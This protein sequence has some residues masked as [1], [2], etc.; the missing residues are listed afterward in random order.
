MKTIVNRTEKALSFA[1]AYIVPIIVIIVSVTV[2]WTVL[3]NAVTENALAIEDLEVRCEKNEEVTELI[4]QRLASID[5]NLE[6]I[7][8]AIERLE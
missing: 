8:R 1:K 2:A 6:Y 7:K 5:T 4:M 3:K